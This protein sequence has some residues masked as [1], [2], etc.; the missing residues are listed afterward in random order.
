MNFVFLSYHYSPGYSS[1]ESWIKRIEGYCG[2]YESL[3]KTDTV[4]A[5]H[6]IDYE[7]LYKNKGV[8]Y[9]F[10]N[11]GKKHTYFPGRLNQFVKDLN[12]DIVV[13]HGL[14]QP[15]ETMQLRF[16]LSRKTKI[17]AQHHAEVPFIGIKKYAQ[18]MAGSCVDAYLFTSCAMGLNWIRKGNLSNPKKI[19]EVMEMSSN[20]YP[21][22]KEVAK[23]KTGLKTEPV[24]LWVGR[25]NEN[26]DPLN[27]VSAFLKF[28][29]AQPSARLYMIYHTDELLS[30]IRKLLTDH[31]NK[32]TVILVG[33]VPH[34]DLLY[35]FNAA[36]FILSGSY[37]EGSGTAVCEAM[38]CG[39]IPIVTDILSFR[40]ITD[41]GKC[42]ILYKAGSERALLAALLQ[43]CQMDRQEKRRLCLDYFRSNLSFEAI[44][45]Q[46]HKIAASL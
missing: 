41:N 33:Q 26:K 44:A 2:L 40:M 7:G 12:P 24:F 35:W 10:V 5:I 34:E 30:G 25:L 29:V 18:R 37:Y 21:L 11:F 31:V 36:D 15:L 19:Y 13:I 28:T 43:T 6:Q 16:L 42:G 20:F 3:S 39:C 38:S 22:D 1:P 8:Q 9:Y 46:F 17:I 23:L 4:A 45:A 32:D 14:H 27:V